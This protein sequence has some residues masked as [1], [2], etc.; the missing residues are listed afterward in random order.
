MIELV[1]KKLDID[2][3]KVD[4]QI[5]KE[6]ENGY[7]NDLTAVNKVSKF[8]ELPKDVKNALDPIQPGV[9]ITIHDAASVN[10]IYI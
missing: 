7:K 2:A 8:T 10:L 4:L 1:A 3:S 6:G 5:A 9:F